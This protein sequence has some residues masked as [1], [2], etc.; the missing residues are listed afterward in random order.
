MP[1]LWAAFDNRSNY[2]GRSTASVTLLLVRHR[3]LTLF[4]SPA[5]T[6]RPLGHTT[7]WLRFCDTKAVTRN[8]VN[9]VVRRLLY[10]ALKTNCEDCPLWTVSG[11]FKALELC[12]PNLLRPQ[13][14]EET[15]HF[16]R[17]R[18]QKVAKSV[19]CGEQLS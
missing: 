7:L 18:Q 15:E 12:V 1:Q 8:P 4:L 9:L 16:H 14:F 2:G 10:M 17:G 5:L 11:L 6:F 13:V 19:Q 3:E